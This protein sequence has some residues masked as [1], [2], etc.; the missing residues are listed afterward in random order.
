MPIKVKLPPKLAAQETPHGLTNS[1]A[2]INKNY[3][4]ITDGPNEIRG[5]LYSE[6]KI[7][8]Y[9]DNKGGRGEEIEGRKRKRRN[10]E[11]GVS[12]IDVRKEGK[13]GNCQLF[14]KKK[15]NDVRN[16]TRH[17]SDCLQMRPNEPYCLKVSISKEKLQ[18]EPND[19]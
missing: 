1:I 7:E 14:K 16:D 4:D 12:G 8:D 15:D 13:G 2:R 5:W 10:S 19:Q 6:D 17:Q 11:E 3:D 9:W 18:P